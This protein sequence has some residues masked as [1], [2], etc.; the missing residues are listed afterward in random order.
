MTLGLA[1]AV[2]RNLLLSI[3]LGGCLQ[4]PEAGT[5]FGPV[6]RPIMVVKAD[7][8]SSYT[9]GC[10]WADCGMSGSNRFGRKT[11]Q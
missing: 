6:E 9:F 1:V 2:S 8:Y 7:I 3:T 4:Y 11:G 10:N 5:S